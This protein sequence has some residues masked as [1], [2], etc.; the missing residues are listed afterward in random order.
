MLIDLSHI[1]LIK[2]LWHHLSKERKRQHIFLLL[3]MF[4]A[5]ISEI[6][7]IGSVLPFLGVLVSPEYIFNLP[8]M[9]YIID[10]FG[11][12]DSSQLLVP[13]TLSFII[14][15]FIAGCIRVLLIYLT[16]RLSFSTGADISVDIFRRTL[17]QPYLV[18]T[19]RNG[20]EVISGV[21]NKTNIVTYEVLLPS[22]NLSSALLMLFFVLLI[23]FSVNPIASLATVFGFGLIYFIFILLTH[24]KLKNNSEKIARES[25]KMIKVLQE[26]LG[27]IR[28]IIIN[29]SQEYYCQIFHKADLPVRKALGN[30]I[31][32]GSSP[33]YIVESLGMIAIA[34]LAVFLSISGKDLALALPIL[35]VV[36][37]G[38]QRSLPILQGA[39]NAVSQLKG[40]RESLQDILDLLDQPLKYEFEREKFEPVVFKNKIELRD[41]SFKYPD[42]DQNILSG[43]NLTFNKGSRIGII[44][45][46]GSGKSTLIDIIMGLISPSEGEL[47][48]DDVVINSDSDS[49][50]V[51]GW[52][53]HISHVPQNI[54]LSDNSV[55]ENIAF[56]MPKNK[57]DFERVN[58]AAVSAQI[59][60]LIDSWDDKFETM[61]G[62]QGIRLSGGQRQRIGIARALYNHTDVIIFDEATSSLD[63]KTEGVVM[64]AIEK[65]DSDKTIFIIAHRLTTLRNCDLVIELGDKGILNI[66]T[67]DQINT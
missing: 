64:D 60:E 59:S 15:A 61:V 52:Q 1:K 20:S 62:E 41:V 12:T 33:R 18:H 65:M 39:Y 49:D 21:V 6:V 30:N 36:A 45:K 46:T 40:S 63:N 17:Y 37:L 57:I 51:F 48:V 67:Y 3:V 24:R 54:Y 22:L 53:E 11:F 50:S 31:F 32:I 28:D 56:G 44:G 25:V 47:I 35:G 2:R 7:S 23:L 43:I 42:K 66:S 29:K 16:T 27:G 4:M 8:Q 14:A 13:L 19:N 58:Q 34:V 26:G 55:K 9:H 38:A 10:Y 5:A